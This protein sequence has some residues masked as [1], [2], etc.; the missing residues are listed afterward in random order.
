MEENFTCPRCGV[1]Q[2]PAETCNS[3]GVHIQRYIELKKSRYIIPSGDSQQRRDEESRENERRALRE[4]IAAKPL[5]PPT[6]GNEQ[7]DNVGTEIPP[8]LPEEDVTQ[9]EFSELQGN[10]TGIGD[11]FQNTWEIFKRRFWPLIALYLLSVFFFVAVFGIFFGFSFFL[12][13]PFPEAQTMIMAGGALVGATAGC[14]A[15]IWGLA[16]FVCGVSDDTLGIK[17]ALSEGSQKIWSFL[18]VFTLLS[19]I[20]TG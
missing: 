9:V 4:S 17:D 13:R 8:L 11:L 12:S 10:L 15:M 18:W 3:C 5:P 2:T 1:A 16:A 14:I 20:I 7:S 6:Q 19:Y